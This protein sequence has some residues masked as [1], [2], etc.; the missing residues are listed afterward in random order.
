MKYN[1][2][3]KATM[4]LACPEGREVIFPF[5]WKNSNPYNCSLKNIF[6]RYLPKINL[7]ISTKIPDNEMD[8][9]TNKAL[10]DH[11]SLFLINLKKIKATAEKIR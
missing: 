11:I 10:F 3:I 6:G 4:V 8:K 2:N 7:V 9:N 1:D 5:S